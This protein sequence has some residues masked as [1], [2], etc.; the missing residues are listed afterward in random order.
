MKSLEVVLIQ[1]DVFLEVEI[2]ALAHVHRRPQKTRWGCTWQFREEASEQK[3]FTLWSWIFSPRTLTKSISVI[4]VIQL[5]YYCYGSLSKLVADIIFTLH[6]I[7]K[8]F[9]IF[10]FL[11]RSREVK[12]KLSGMGYSSLFLQ[13]N[14]VI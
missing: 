12:W 13:H 4:K 5:L 14:Q 9:F 10:I 11:N 8:G 2:R 7:L 1:F 3:L 6:F